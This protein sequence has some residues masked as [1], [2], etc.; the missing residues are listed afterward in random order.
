MKGD[1]PKP[2][3]LSIEHQTKVRIE[4]ARERF[5]WVLGS[6]HKMLTDKGRSYLLHRDGLKEVFGIAAKE[7]PIAADAIAVLIW[8][9]LHQLYMIEF[10][11][12]DHAEAGS[13][14]TV[15]NGDTENGK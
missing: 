12:R 3:V 15:P 13:R 4:R 11:A 6:K 7:C 10:L 8:D 14:P 9:H 1:L 2:D 5:E